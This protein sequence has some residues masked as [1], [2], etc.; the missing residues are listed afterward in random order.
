MEAGRESGLSFLFFAP[1]A[2]RIHRTA[3]VT[4]PAGCGCPHSPGA[5]LDI[6]AQQQP[7]AERRLNAQAKMH[8]NACSNDNPA[9]PRQLSTFGA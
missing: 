4:A 8:E 1:A 2:C 7:A 3:A 9:S 5:G 6:E